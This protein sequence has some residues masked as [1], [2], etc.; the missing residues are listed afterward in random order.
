[1]VDLSSLDPTQ[2]D[3]LREECVLV[4]QDDNV[5]GS[6]S[7]KNCHLNEQIKAGKLHR[8]FSVFLFNSD[9]KLLIQQRASS[10]ITFPGCFTN[11]VCSHPLHRE[12]EMEKSK[13]IGVR[14]AAR[15]KMDHELG[16]PEDQVCIINAPI[17]I[18]EV[19][20]FDW[21]WEFMANLCIYV[22]F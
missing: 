2:V 6:D 4:D 20:G 9:G 16:I 1:M 19:E 3:L 7:K 12:E 5:I 13:A 17:G 15:R 18:S 14:R 21:L 11:T 10:K 8:A 22:S